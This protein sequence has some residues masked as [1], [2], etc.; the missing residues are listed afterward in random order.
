MNNGL[1]M[2][3]EDLDTSDYDMAVEHTMY[4]ILENIGENGNTD[5]IAKKIRSYAIELCRDLLFPTEAARLIV[6]QAIARYKD[7]LYSESWNV[8]VDNT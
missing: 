4:F 5:T 2:M 6:E 8:G 3:L 7:G 1:M